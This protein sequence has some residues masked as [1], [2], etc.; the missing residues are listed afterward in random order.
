[1]T[2]IAKVVSVI[3]RNGDLTMQIKAIVLCAAVA[4]ALNLP[5]SAAEQS[6]VPKGWTATDNVGKQFEV[7]YDSREGAV[8]LRSVGDPGDAKAA[9][10]QSIDPRPYTSKML[11]LTAEV[12]ADESVRGE[13]FVRERL[14]KSTASAASWKGGHDWTTVRVQVLRAFDKP[15]DTLDFG[16]VLQGKGRMWMRNIQITDQVPRTE[17][18]D[19]IPMHESI[20]VV[21]ALPKPVNLEL[22]P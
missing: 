16:F 1:M 9:L 5:L 11:I 4:A 14:G 22:R 19:N 10:T 13:V 21:A 12:R 18:V 7:G 15:Q 6:G 3:N 20:P 2:A 17:K 8:Y